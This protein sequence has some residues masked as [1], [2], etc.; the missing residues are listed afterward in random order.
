MAESS[1][2][3]SAQLV[4]VRTPSSRILQQCHQAR[5]R[6]GS[7]NVPRSMLQ[8]GRRCMWQ[9]PRPRPQPETLLLHVSFC[10]TSNASLFLRPLQVPHVRLALSIDEST[11]A[12]K[13]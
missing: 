1:R 3:E 13:N 4:Q 5:R 6:I 11:S 7:S 10:R 9:P 12:R 8:A 2:P